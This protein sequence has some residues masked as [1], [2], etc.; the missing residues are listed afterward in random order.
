MS[1]ADGV[2]AAVLQQLATSRG[3]AGG[4]S[5]SRRPA[6]P[7]ASPAG[8]LAG[9]WDAFVSVGCQLFSGKYLSIEIEE[10]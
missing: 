5:G 3:A 2:E 8:A 7:R 6:L 1:W 4:Q 9:Q 10:L